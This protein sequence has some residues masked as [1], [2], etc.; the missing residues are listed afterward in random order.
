MPT[1]APTTLRLGHFIDTFVTPVVG[2]E[3]LEDKTSPQYLA[4]A[5]LADEDEYIPE[6]KTLGEL[7]DR[8]AL[9]VF[10]FA[11]GGDQWTQCSR[12]DTS[13]AS[14]WLIGDHCDWFGVT[15]N[16]DGRVISI[17]FSSDNGLTGS[18]PPELSLLSELEEFV[19][20][21]NAVEGIDPEILSTPSQ[22]PTTLRLGHFLKVWV[23][24]IVGE[25]VLEDRTSYQYLAAEY[26]ADFDDYIPSM[27]TVEELEDRFAVTTFYFATGGDQWTQCSRSDTSCSSPWLTGDHCDWFGITCN[28]DGRIVSIVFTSDIGLTGSVPP[29]A[30]LASEL[31][32]FVIT[33][34]S[35]T[36]SQMGSKGP[37]N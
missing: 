20:T 27:T 35:G 7:E 23:A 26:L 32:E 10:Y 31:D 30:Y 19:I 16:E 17:V 22:A 37:G 33:Q 4:A 34:D 3:V 11:T 13:C 18:V 15:C 25:E 5:F 28:E 12:Y 2:E 14:P 9:V 8:F 24:P 6:L 36:V 29:E 1:E 21:D